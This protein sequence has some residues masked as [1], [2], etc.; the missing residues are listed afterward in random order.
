[1]P[2]NS[3]SGGYLLPDVP[4]APTPLEGTDL[5][6]FFHDWIV[7]LTGIDPLLVRPGWQPTATNIPQSGT[8]WIAF[9]IVDEES[10]IFPWQGNT[11]NPVPDSDPIYQFQRNE[12]FGVVCSVYG[13]GAGSD[14]RKIAFLL[15][16]DSAIVQ[17]QEPLFNAG[18]GLIECTAPQPAPILTKTIWLYRIDLTLRIRRLVVRTYD[19]QTIESSEVDFTIDAETNEIDR[20]TTAIQE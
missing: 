12:Q 2:T 7:G 11:V 18:M 20:T 14:A 19:V 4:P 1:M 6:D 16:D 13:T 3:S 17:N 8:V 5:E 10:D 9:H 15:R